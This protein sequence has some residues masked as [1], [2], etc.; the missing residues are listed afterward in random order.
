MAEGFNIW[1]ILPRKQSKPA[2]VPKSWHSFAVETYGRFY[3]RLY[4]APD[5]AQPA[6]PVVPFPMA[7]FTAGFCAFLLY[8]LEIAILSRGNF[9]LPTSELNLDPAPVP[10]SPTPIT[11]SWPGTWSA[12]WMPTAPT[13]TLLTPWGISWLS[14]GAVIKGNQ[15][16]EA[17]KKAW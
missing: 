6:E 16:V 15:D 7:Q 17:E 1:L 4:F 5:P 2:R 14:G 13:S 11:T 12:Q 3:G 8:S 10:T 9:Q